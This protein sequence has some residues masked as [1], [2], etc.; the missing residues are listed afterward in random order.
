MHDYGVH[1]R[2]GVLSLAM[3]YHNISPSNNQ[4][5]PVCTCSLT[6]GTSWPLGLFSRVAAAQCATLT[7]RMVRPPRLLPPVMSPMIA[8][9]AADRQRRNARAQRVRPNSPDRRSVCRLV[10]ERTAVS[11]LEGER[12]LRAKAA[13]VHRVVAS[14]GAARAS[15]AA[16]GRK[17]G[18]I[19]V[20]DDRSRPATGPDCTLWVFAAHRRERVLQVRGAVP[21]ALAGRLHRQVR[22]RPPARRAAARPAFVRRA[23]VRAVR[24]RLTD[25]RG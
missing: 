13:E 10:R 2:G 6:S 25:C 22:A 24:R 1:R 15:P 20:P 16:L 3:Q 8:D 12:R 21:V 19:P 23:R 11:A 9:L 14:L 5:C 17:L 7:L 4:F 18:A